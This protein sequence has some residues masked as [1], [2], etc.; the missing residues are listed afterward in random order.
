MRR[1]SEHR[2]DTAH[3]HDY[4]ASTPRPTSPARPR[5]YPQTE[6]GGTSPA[7]R[8]VGGCLGVWRGDVVSPP[9]AVRSGAHGSCPKVIPWLDG[10]CSMLGSW[11]KPPT[12]D[13]IRP[14]RSGLAPFWPPTRPCSCQ[15]SRITRSVVNWPAWRRPGRFA[16][17]M[18]SWR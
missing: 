18:R 9:R 7:S 10:S 3:G 16:A 12:H 14:L 15:R 17:S 5:R 2:G 13:G 4:E 8:M 1:L 6:C 11:G